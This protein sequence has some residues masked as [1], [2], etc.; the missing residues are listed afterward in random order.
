MEI[1]LTEKEMIEAEE[2]ENL[3]AVNSEND[4]I[5]EWILE[6]NR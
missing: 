2:I 5:Q 4:E 6:L 1:I 3:V